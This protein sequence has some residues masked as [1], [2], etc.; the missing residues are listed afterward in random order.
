MFDEIN[1]TSLISRKSALPQRVRFL[2]RKIFARWLS[3][4]CFFFILGCTQQLCQAAEIGDAKVQF[5]LGVMYE[6]GRGV[7]QDERQAVVW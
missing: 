1:T 4:L 7:R 2:V 3:I 6:N 5:N